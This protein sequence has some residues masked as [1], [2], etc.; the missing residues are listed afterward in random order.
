MNYRF[1]QLLIIIFLVLRTK[2]AYCQGCSDAGFC[3]MGALKP[4]QNPNIANK[5][6]LRSIELTNYFAFTPVSRLEGIFAQ[7]NDYFHT[8]VADANIG[9]G[10]NYSF[11]VKMPY[12]FTYGVLANTSGIGDISYGLSRNLY[13]SQDLQIGLTLG[14]KIPTGESNLKVNERPLPMY[15]QPGLGTWDALAGVGVNYKSFLFTF[16]IQHPFNAN[17]NTFLWTPWKLLGGQDSTNAL[18]Y[19]RTNQFVRGTDLMF[20]VEYNLRFANWNLHTGLLNIFRINKDQF[21]N[22]I[23][24]A[25]EEIPFS[26]GLVSSFIFGGTYR[27]DTQSSIKIICAI[28]LNDRESDAVGKEKNPNPDGLKRYF[29]NTITYEYRF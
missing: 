5:L 26:N 15:Y 11:Q 1:W 13:Q 28:R 3:T 9:I 25:F 21:K 6:N 27:F 24:N 4:N 7:V 2:S 22:P 10:K 16:G 8:I 17:N 12:N 23:K 18:H 14:G 29:V 20:R 19:S